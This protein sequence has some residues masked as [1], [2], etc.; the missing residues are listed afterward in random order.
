[1]EAMTED[2][3]TQKRGITFVVYNVGNFAKEKYESNAVEH[4]AS[5]QNSLPTKSCSIHYCFNDSGFRYVIN[6][7]M[8]FFSEDARARVKVH[9]GT[10]IECSYSLMTFGCPINS[11][12]LSI[13]GDLKKKA[14]LEFIKMRYQQEMRVHLPRI[15]V[16]THSDVVFGR[17]KKWKTINI[18]E[19]T[20]ELNFLQTGKP[21]RQHIGNKKLH[22]MMDE[23]LKH[24]Q[25]LSTKNKRLATI[26]K[27]MEAIQNGGGRFLQQDKAGFWVEIDEKAVQE[28]VLRA[29]R[30]RLRNASS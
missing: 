10:H 12:P 18:W 2:V 20:L 22:A 3:E 27:L 30:I 25:S 19:K 11:L 7:A 1:M 17:G 26:E 13:D 23:E 5:I 16:P 9:F 4:T 24:E 6:I 29:F 15:V 21:Y 28:K 14:H 8:R